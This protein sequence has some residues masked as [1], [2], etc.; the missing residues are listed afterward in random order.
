MG[1]NETPY[2]DPSDWDTVNSAALHGVARG[3]RP[4]PNWSLIYPRSQRMARHPFYP[5]PRWVRY[6]LW[7]VL[8][9][10]AWARWW[11]YDAY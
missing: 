8:M 1:P 4:N 6:L 3:I 2:T 7:W 5:I 10:R 9:G 11:V